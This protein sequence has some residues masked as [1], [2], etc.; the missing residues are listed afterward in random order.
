MRIQQKWLRR[1]RP[2]TRNL[3]IMVGLMGILI[4]IA[5]SLTVQS[6]DV[7]PTN[8]WVD[9]YSTASSYL[10]ARVP[11]GA[12]IAVF[13][14]QGVQ[15]GAATVTSAGMYG[16]M[17]CYGD[18]PLTP[19]DEGAAFGDV[20]HFTI[21]GLAA[22]T[23]AISMNGAPVPPNTVVMWSPVQSLWQVNLHAG[24]GDG[25]PTATATTIGVS[26]ATPTRTPTGTLTRTITPTPSSSPTS[27][28]T[29]TATPS[30]TV[31]PTKTVMA[32]PSHTPTSSPAVTG[33]PTR[34]PTPTVTATAT[35]TAT[36]TSH[37]VWLPL[38]LR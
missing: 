31:S 30:A 38:G 12:E 14:P 21:N 18:D 19:Q 22:Q 3:W 25:T 34:T 29:P 9:F 24:T 2:Q 13:D 27:T 28:V 33:A 35:R 17:P 32:P 20:L 5:S 7:K 36:H 6:G 23:Q 4:G 16:I 10:G 8:T 15:C 1:E 26:T 37:Q 11:P